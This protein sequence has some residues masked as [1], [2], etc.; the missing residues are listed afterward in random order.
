MLCLLS[1]SVCFLH[2]LQSVF[3]FKLK[4]DQYF[5]LMINSPPTECYIWSTLSCITTNENLRES[6]SGSLCPAG[7]SSV[8]HDLK[9]KEMGQ[10]VPNVVSFHGC[11]QQKEVTFGR[12]F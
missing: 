1:S 5:A 10:C 7:I 4:A 3:K 6:Q 2:D 12:S 9:Q 8:Q 11:F